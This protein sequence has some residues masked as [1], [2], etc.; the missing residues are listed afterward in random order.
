MVVIFPMDTGNQTWVLWNSSKYYQQWVILQPLFIFMV[1]F[2][3]VWMLCLC[4]IYMLCLTRPEE[5]IRPPG[6]RGKDDSCHHVLWTGIKTRSSVKAARALNCRT[7][8]RS[9]PHFRACFVL[10]CFVTAT[11]SFKDQV[12][13]LVLSFLTSADLSLNFLKC[14]QFGRHVHPCS[15]P[16]S[17]H[18]SLICHLKVVILSVNLLIYRPFLSFHKQQKLLRKFLWWCLRRLSPVL[19]ALRPQPAAPAGFCPGGLLCMSSVGRPTLPTVQWA[20][21]SSST[22]ALLPPNPSPGHFP[23]LR[24]PLGLVF[25]VSYGLVYLMVVAINLVTHT[26]THTHTHY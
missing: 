7:V 1:C 3:C 17:T 4:T 13:S 20:L 23:A 15:S 14:F 18:G 8:H 5:G 19:L 6:T 16:S 21:C 26:H 24:I 11:G 10:F 12:Q 22:T 25:T 9:G 2:L